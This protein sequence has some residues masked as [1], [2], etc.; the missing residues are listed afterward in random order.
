MEHQHSTVKAGSTD[1]S[2]TLQHLTSNMNQSEW[3]GVQCVARLTISSFEV[4]L[5]FDQSSQ[6]VHLLPLQLVQLRSDMMADKV[7]FFGQLT[8][9]YYRQI[10][11]HFILNRTPGCDNAY[12]KSTNESD[13]SLEWYIFKV[14][15][16][17]NKPGEFALAILA[18]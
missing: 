10:M 12:H 16:T 9:L 14:T 11:A 2:S 18:K 4:L 3:K 7:Q 6:S 8:L 1:A 5:G 13:L 17:T 15:G